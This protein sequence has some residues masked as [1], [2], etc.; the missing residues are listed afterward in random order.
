MNQ[1]DHNKRVAN[2]DA[3][4]HVTVKSPKPIT[5]KTLRKAKV[6]R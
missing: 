4:G 6:K 3:Y 1:V 2:V 5:L